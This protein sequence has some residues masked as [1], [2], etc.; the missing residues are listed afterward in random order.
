MADSVE[1][2]IAAMYLD[3]NIE[4]VERFILSNL[5]LAIEIASRHVGAKDYKTVLQE[6]LQIHG[7]VHISYTTINEIGPDHNKTFVVELSVN[8]EKKSQGTGN[9]KKEAEMN[10]AK[11]ALKLL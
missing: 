5:K 7:D 6:K 11:E 10:A 2:L 1:A 8:G 9:N 4:T 3:S